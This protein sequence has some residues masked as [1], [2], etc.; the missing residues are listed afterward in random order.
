MELFVFIFAVYIFYSIFF[1]KKDKAS[2]QENIATINNADDDL[3]EFR[4]SYGCNDEVESKN[5]APG[6]WIQPNEII[7]V[8]GHEISGG[9]FYFGGQL[10]ALDGYGT[11]SSLV[12]GFLPIED[13][14]HDFEDH[15]LGYWPKYNSLSPEGRGAYISWLAGERNNPETPIGYVFIYFYG[16]ERRILVDFVDGDISDEEC[17]TLYNEVTRLNSIYGKNWSF[18]QYSTRLIEYLSIIAPQISSINDEDIE[19]SIESI[20]FKYRLAKVVSLEN[21]ISPQLALAWIRNHPDHNLRT[22]ARRCSKEF[23][24]LFIMRYTEQFGEGFIVKP[25]KTKLRLNY[26]P[27]SSS[28]RGYAYIHLNLPDPSV[29]KAPVKKLAAIVDECTDKLDAYSRYLGKKTSSPD[30]LAAI[31]LLPN[32]LL[33]CSNSPLLTSFKSWAD[34]KL[35]ESAGLVSI[36]D[37]W[38]QIGEPLPDIINKKEIEL[39]TNIATKTGYGIA[40]DPKYHHAKPTLDGNLVLFSEGHGDYF[41]PSKTFY[42]VGITLR[43]GAMVACIDNHLDSSEVSM[44][45]KIIDHDIKLSPVEQK[46]LHAYL[47]WRL[48]TP[49]NMTG[50]KANL[51]N[52]GVKE[53]TAVSHILVGIA[54]ADGVIDPREIK[55]LEKLYTALGLDKSMVTSDIH[56]L[57]SPRRGIKTSPKITSIAE[58]GKSNQIP[59]AFNLDDEILAIH[60]SETQDVQ[61]ML[62]AIFSDDDLDDDVIEAA[63]PEEKVT[64]HQNKDELNAK[65]QE[66]YDHLIN[67]DEWSRE[68]IHAFCS[69]SG[70]MVSGAIETIN[71][72][73]FEKVNAPAL[74][75]NGDIILIDREIVNELEE[76]ED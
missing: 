4:I 73:A 36:K 74:E 46:S 63:S 28:L 13:A 34:K 25:N 70:L 66:L 18:N 65:L 48:N 26:H 71:D 2:H 58:K 29:L 6:I 30:D 16:L 22:P 5:K 62:S 15:S 64:A 23:N 35:S 8:C 37:F 19:D 72:W 67:K 31:L 39:I 53:K 47:L 11:E 40:P 44:L 51:A 10:K 76:L 68:D 14:D 1:K 7:Q 57:S 54:L 41:T 9:F 24:Q 3:C 43:L 60:E 17:L 56:V 59:S 45:N 12:D 20:L 27:A 52:I 49:A 61:S 38:S 42:E 75:D 50:L 33:N 21:P 55:Q 69:K 32:D